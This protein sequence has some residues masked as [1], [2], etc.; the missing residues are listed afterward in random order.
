MNLRKAQVLAAGKRRKVDRGNSQTRT[1]WF[2]QIIF[3][4]SERALCSIHRQL[5]LKIVANFSATSTAWKFRPYETHIQKNHRV[6]LHLLSRIGKHHWRRMVKF[7]LRSVCQKEARGRL[8]RP[9]YQLQRLGQMTGIDCL[10]TDN[11]KTCH[12]LMDNTDCDLT[13]LQWQ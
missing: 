8:A 12:R 2:C 10:L 1:Y 9:L 5:R 6:G 11:V 3:W 4:K 7:C 13:D